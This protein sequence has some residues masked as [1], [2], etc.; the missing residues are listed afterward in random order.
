MVKKDGYMERYTQM[1]GKNVYTVR[2]KIGYLIV[3]KKDSLSV[4]YCI[5]VWRKLWNYIEWCGILFMLLRTTNYEFV[6]LICDLKFSERGKY[7]V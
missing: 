7:N 5:L 6:R 2:G 3:R 1:I 4:F